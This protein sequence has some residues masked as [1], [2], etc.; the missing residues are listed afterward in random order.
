MTELQR[1]LEN[2][3]NCYSEYDLIEIRGLVEQGLE[4][5]E[6][7]LGVMYANGWCVERDYDEAVRLLML[8]AGKGYGWAQTHMG[9]M[10]ENGNGVQRSNARAVEWYRLAA[11]QKVA[12]AQNNLGVMYNRGWGVAPNIILAHMWFNLA[13]LGGYESVFRSKETLE[14]QMQPEQIAEAERLAQEWRDAHP[15]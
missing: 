15:E 6:F 11:E 2:M 5:A 12:E 13:T 9:I 14:S 4:G 7:R 8:S 10:Y 3:E 1:L